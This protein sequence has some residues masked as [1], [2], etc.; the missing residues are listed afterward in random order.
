VIAAL[1]G[2]AAALWWA[3]VWISLRDSVLVR[4]PQLD[5]LHYLR[6]AA[7]IGGG[8]LLPDEPFYMSPLYPAL[9]AVLGGGGAVDPAG[10]VTRLPLG[11]WAA[12]AA[13]WFGIGWL[14][15]R[16]A[17]RV[18]LGW[19]YEGRAAGRLALL[20]V[21]LY[22]LY[23]PAAVFTT[24]PL[25]EIPLTL[26][27][28]AILERLSAWSVAPDLADQTDVSRPTLTAV[29]VIG[30]GIGL[31]TL[32]RS[33]AVLLLGPASLV[34]LAARR[35]PARTGPS[36]AVLVVALLITLL[37]TLAPVIVFNS[38][39][40]G[41]P[42]GVSLNGGVNLYI[43][44]GPEARGFFTVFA[45]FDFAGDSAGVEYLSRKLERPVADRVEADRI[46]GQEAW[47][48]VRDDPGRAAALYLKKVWLHFQGWEI[49]Q[50]TPL[51]AWVDAAPPLRLLVV[52][53]G[54]VSALG[55]AGLVVLPWR[56][57]RLR[58]WALALVV[59]VAGQSLF[60]V[61]ARYRQVIVPILAL[62]AGL[63]LLRP[64]GRG[65]RRLVAGLLLVCLVVTRPW[66]L[67]EVRE[68][69]LALGWTN[70]ALR[71]ELRAGWLPAEHGEDRER[72]ARLYEE[73]LTVVPDRP[74]SYRGLARLRHAAGD[75]DGALGVLEQGIEG[76]SWPDP[77]RRDRIEI[78]LLEGR[79]APALAV[80]EDYLRA[81]PR[82]ADM[83]HNRTVLLVRSGDPATALASAR[84]LAELVPEDP[85]AWLDLGVVL[86]RGGDRAGA[87]AA[88]VE[89]LRRHPDHPDLAANLARLE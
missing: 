56:D 45:E 69:W 36:P 32:L 39:R 75:V 21:A 86:A 38:L 78:L 26:V 30:V 34:L 41:R 72:A 23:R 6:E 89:G 22:L 52:P 7:A 27:V 55:L 70:E 64:A 18:L 54:L 42:A 85:R 12:Q 50:L 3:L 79:A 29:A 74:D 43:G 5:E 57:R 37:I 48:A 15:H 71:L 31:A 80:L 61:V 59:L 53:Y 76:S 63:L 35:P 10:L 62:F 67:D 68:R 1:L 47:R 58:P 25:L 81:H 2:A 33:H 11:L 19:G 73:A 84:R 14:L 4:V 82:D 60:F 16:T 46:W 51:P 28:V 20:P 17:R 49:D 40:A 66:G 9:V 77:L 83:L 24:L 88:F 87:R 13:M 8:R 44:N 65:Q